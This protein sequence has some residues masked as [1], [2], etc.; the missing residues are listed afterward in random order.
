MSLTVYFKTNHIIVIQHSNCNPGHSSE[1]NENLCSLKNSQ[2]P[3][4]EYYNSL[5]IMAKISFVTTF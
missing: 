2:R 3:A 4:H 1:M 5:F